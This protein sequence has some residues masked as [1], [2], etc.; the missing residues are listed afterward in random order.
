M[1]YA[2]APVEEKRWKRPQRLEAGYVYGGDGGGFDATKWGEV[3]PQVPFPGMMD[4]LE[5]GEDCLRVNVWMPAGE[6]P[7]EGWPVMV[8]FHGE[9]SIFSA[10]EGDP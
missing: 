2:A 8:W 5:Y 3:C 10:T 9:L 7:H 6:T 4:K 1:P